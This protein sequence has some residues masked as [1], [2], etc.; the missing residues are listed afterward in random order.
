[1]GCE[2]FDS[3]GDSPFDRKGSLS[4][5][6]IPFA[7]EFVARSAAPGGFSG[8]VDFDCPCRRCGYNLRGLDALGRCPECGTPVG[9]SAHGDL[10]RF[11][12]PKWLQTISSG[13]SLVL[14]GVLVSMLV[15]MLSRLLSAA[16]S[17]VLVAGLGLIGS[18]IYVVG[19]YRFTEPDP[20]GLSD[21]K[22]VNTRKF[23][24]I[25]LALSMIGTASN[26]VGL[27]ARL[28]GPI[29]P[30]MAVV[31]LLLLAIGYIGEWARLRYMRSLALRIPEPKLA[32]AAA[33]LSWAYPITS[34]I[35]VLG[36]GALAI[37]V[38]AAGPAPTMPTGLAIFGIAMMI[39]LLLLLLV[40]L[41]WVRV[42]HK[43][44][45]ALTEQAK[46]AERVWRLGGG[47]VN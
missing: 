20:S 42:Q 4:M 45:K 3:R 36:A 47:S 38:M 33:F 13:L 34:A 39:N 44:Q 43:L 2:P 25:A 19:A 18:I 22:Y 46:I 21:G 16:G 27:F 30:V 31:G 8:Q 29:G 17:Q 7:T 10:L 6:E 15:G 24:R 37:I 40:F 32:A 11:A 35:M 41:R 12:D 9:L 23:V 14:W 26:A 1:M 28:P 5:S